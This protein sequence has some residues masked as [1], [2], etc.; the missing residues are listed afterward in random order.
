MLL[1]KKE[2][3]KS[4]LCCILKKFSTFVCGSYRVAELVWQVACKEGIRIPQDISLT[5]FDDPRHLSCLFPPLTTV[6]QPFFEAGVL[7]VDILMKL[8]EGKKSKESMEDGKP[9][10][11]ERIG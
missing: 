9:D 6:K 11:L 8:R 7:A 1:T 5:G 2:K 3:G 4:L 10:N